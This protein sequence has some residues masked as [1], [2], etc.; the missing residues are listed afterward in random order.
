MS[1]AAKGYPGLR[2]AGAGV[3]DLRGTPRPF[4]ANDPR[5]LP[6]RGARPIDVFKWEPNE[7]TLGRRVAGQAAAAGGGLAAR[8]AL[9]VLPYIGAALTAYE[10][11]TILTEGGDPIPRDWDVPEDRELTI[12]GN[13]SY[14]AVAEVPPAFVASYRDES[15]PRYLR[16]VVVPPEIQTYEE[17]GIP[18]ENEDWSIGNGYIAETDPADLVANGAPV[19]KRVN[20]QWHYDATPDWSGQVI[21]T[22]AAGY[23]Y[24]T[25]EGA[26]PT[27]TNPQR[28][29]DPVAVPVAVPVQVPYAPP[30][31]RVRDGLPEH[32]L[33]TRGEPGQAPTAPP[34][35]T[36]PPTWVVEWPPAPQPGQPAP[37]PGAG[38]APS[39]RPQPEPARPREPP[40]KGE[41]EKKG[42]IKG[43][44]GQAFALIKGATNA[45]TEGLDLINALY[46][47]LPKEF[48]PGYVQ[49][50]YRDKVT[51]ELKTYWKRRWT[52]NQQQR[53]EAVAK[54]FDK[55]NMEDA[56]RNMLN[57][58]AEDRTYGELGRH[59]RNSRRGN[60]GGASGGGFGWQLGEWDSA[61]SKAAWDEAFRKRVAEERAA[62]DKA[63]AKKKRR[64]GQFGN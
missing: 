13:W 43:R 36:V 51:G 33:T 1:A 35:P 34:V 62:R 64:T 25:A 8:Q 12:P 32:P 39:P 15:A 44:A 18:W 38:P 48:R 10:I 40:G 6:N 28:V 55:I 61:N 7:R 53:A 42:N 17:N 5:K 46:K 54:H 23:Y 24:K 4:P 57:N 22:R 29:T 52:A 11:Y 16:E 31:R 19:G 45:A 3:P 21:G 27:F 50:H 56:I 2:R 41:E 9:R 14:T 63:L 30:F 20:V 47:A 60:H 49:L 37:S 58:N 59:S 26:N